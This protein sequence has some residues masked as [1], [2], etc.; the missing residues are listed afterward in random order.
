M[1][2]SICKN[3]HASWRG[4][5]IASLLATRLKPLPCEMAAS[6]ASPDSQV[7]DLDIA[8][9][10]RKIDNWKTLSP[11]LGLAPQDETVIEKSCKSYPEEKSA[12]LH[13]W[14][15]MKGKKAT[16]RALIAAARAMESENLV[17]YVESLTAAGD[18]RQGGRAAASEAGECFRI[19]HT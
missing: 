19:L 8:K 11:F 7:S 9:I 12:A 4:V 6:L 13:K 15:D 1:S 3:A 17:D 14:R 5:Y 16:Y 18:I 10:A 2:L